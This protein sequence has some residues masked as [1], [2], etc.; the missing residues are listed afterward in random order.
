MK[1]DENIQNITKSIQGLSLNVELNDFVNKLTEI[2]ELKK[3]FRS[4][5]DERETTNKQIIEAAA[6]CKILSSSFLGD[7]ENLYYQLYLILSYYEDTS[8]E[9]FVLFESQFENSVQSSNLEMGRNFFDLTEKITAL[10]STIHSIQQTFKHHLKIHQIPSK[11][12]EQ[13]YSTDTLLLL[14]NGIDEKMKV[15]NS[16]IMYIE[17]NLEHDQDLVIN[18]TPISSKKSAKKENAERN[19][20]Q[21]NQVLYMQ[22][23]KW[24]EIATKVKFR[25]RPC[26]SLQLFDEFYH[27]TSVTVS[28]PIKI[29]SAEEQKQISIRK[30]HAKLYYTEKEIL[31]N[32]PNAS[33]ASEFI[34]N[35]PDLGDWSCIHSPEMKNKPLEQPKRDQMKTEESK[36]GKIPVLTEFDESKSPLKNALD[37]INQLNYTKVIKEVT[38]TPPTAAPSSFGLPPQSKD[39]KSK[40]SFSSFVEPEL[41]KHGRKISLDLTDH[42]K[43]THQE[44]TSEK[45]IIQPETTPSP[46][47]VPISSGGAK[48]IT[49]SLESSATSTTTPAT[50]MKLAA[51]N[52]LVEKIKDIYKAH[53]PEKLSEVPAL[54]QK[55]QGKHEEL[56]MRLQRKYEG[57]KT[58]ERTSPTTATTTTTLGNQQPLPSFGTSTLGTPAAAPTLTTPAAPVTAMPSLFNKPPQQQMS[59]GIGSPS[60]MSPSSSQPS[61]FQLQP[62][63]QSQPQLQLQPSENKFY[64]IVHEIY[65]K[66]NPQKLDEINNLLQKYDGKELE[67]I[68]RLKK[69][70]NI[71]D[72]IQSEK[73]LFTGIGSGGGGVLG[74]QSSLF[75]GTNNNSNMNNTPT[76][77]GGGGFLNQSSQQQQPPLLSGGGQQN[78]IVAAPAPAVGVGGGNSLFTRNS[79]VTNTM[80]GFQSSATQ[81]NN[82]SNPS[83]FGTPAANTGALATTSSLF[84]SGGGGLLGGG[85]GGSVAANNNNNS[86]F[87]NP[88]LNPSAVTPQPSQQQPPQTSLFG[89]GF[90]GGVKTPFGG[91]NTTTTPLGGGFTLAPSTPF[92]NNSN[93]SN[94]NPITPFTGQVN[95]SSLFGQQTQPQQLL[96]GGGGGTTLFSGNNSNLAT[97][98]N[99]VREIYSQFNPTKIAEIP[100]LMQKYKGKEMELIQKLEQ[101]YGAGQG[102]PA[103]QQQAQTGFGFMMGNNN[104]NNTNSV[105]GN[106]NN[107]AMN[108]TLL[109]G[110]GFQQASFGNSGMMQ[111]NNMNN[112][113]NLMGGNLG[114]GG[115]VGP[116]G[117]FAG[118][119]TNTN[120]PS[121]FGGLNNSTNNNNSTGGGIGF[122]MGMGQ[123]TSVPA[124]GTTSGFGST[125][126]NRS[127][128]GGNT[129]NTGFGG[130][131]G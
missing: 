102:Q 95:T 16:R 4:K 125:K 122:G 92:N 130:F 79:P 77:F 5:C 48:K 116:G 54:L 46:L 63:Q 128:F 86:F 28:T 13:Q 123:N 89:G 9:Y 93:I 65:Q 15:I 61:L 18:R 43:R 1:N 94:N 126:Q 71:T 109:G 76:P 120:S 114:V 22:K 68:T 45:S 91:S 110:G 103:Q 113:N 35:S 101:K 62:T 119:S 111:N 66:Y 106:T 19:S 24:K 81:I 31:L 27:E 50:T 47:T 23:Q 11:N 87:N 129:S 73:T 14:L 88:T 42:H 69:K 6:K 64:S 85:F 44:D 2:V 82:T 58:G 29:K 7:N 56:L 104:N 100:N 41:I 30:T 83:P 10:K 39:D 55:Y 21:N 124:F 60:F 59:S 131:Q 108:N 36:L 25:Y 12:N 67:L 97:V 3:L 112:N 49:S 105:F 72:P 96:G 118:N 37:K 121:L 53:N 75:G 17:E 51:E 57:V 52:A 20:R 80:G 32:T 8:Y 33:I 70:Y 115:G 74:G 98:E 38:T 107:N 84:N 90:G 127:L 117:L 78:A 99:R 26:Y 34:L 40:I